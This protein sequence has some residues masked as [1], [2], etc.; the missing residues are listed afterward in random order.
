MLKR[1]A[2]FCVLSFSFL[3]TMAQEDV[4]ESYAVLNL[5]SSARVAAMGLDFLPFYTNDVSVGI[6]NPSILSREMNNQFSIGYT[7][8]FA[9]I[10]QGNF[11]YSRT[12]DKLGSFSF[13]MNYIGYGNFRRMEASGD[14][15]GDFSA[16]DYMFTIGWGRMLEENLYFGANMKPIISQYDNYSS[17][18]IAF[19]VAATYL[20]DDKSLTATFMVRN[21]G[22]QITS[23]ANTEE[24]LPFELQFGFSKKLAHAPFRFY[25]VATDLQKW[26]LRENDPL[27]PRDEIDPFTGIITRENTF[28]GIL[29]NTFRHLQFAADF[30]PSKNFYASFGYSWKQSRE[31]YIEDAFS[32][33]GL[34][35][36]FG[37]SVKK[38]RISY[39]RNEYHKFGSPNHLTLLVSI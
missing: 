8:L 25:V 9:G 33:A 24:K 22:A 28:K 16:N 6:T 23:Y 4:Y 13:G 1:F 30:Q 34:S 31:M 37:F 12:F 20:S 19:D 15:T 36:G 2:I 26:D 32:L 3:F 39:A 21:F 18:A 5:R 38:F 7:D 35:Y 27:N 11:A 17:T 14:Q 29:D 10:W